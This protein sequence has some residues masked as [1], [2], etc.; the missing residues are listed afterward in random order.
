MEQ[1]LQEAVDK[2]DHL[3]QQN[4]SLRQQLAELQKG[5]QTSQ[6]SSPVRHHKPDGVAISQ[7][8]LK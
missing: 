6:V 2:S 5:A 4:E 7:A 8:H 3:Q 1:E